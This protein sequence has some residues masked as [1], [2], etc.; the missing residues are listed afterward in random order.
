[1]DILTISTNGSVLL[2]TFDFPPVELYTLLARVL[3]CCLPTPLPFLPSLGEQQN[4]GLFNNKAS[5]IKNTMTF[6]ITLPGKLVFRPV[7]ITVSLLPYQRRKVKTAPLLKGSVY[8]T[9]FL[10]E[11]FTSRSQVLT[12]RQSGASNSFCQNGHARTFLRI[13]SNYTE[14][15]S[16]FVN[17]EVECRSLEIRARRLRRESMKGRRNKQKISVKIQG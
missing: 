16:S 1:M 14:N 5:T 8:V 9:I 10:D 3:Y 11:N 17:Q 15:S 12:L 2:C 4:I 13:Q 7:K 6:K